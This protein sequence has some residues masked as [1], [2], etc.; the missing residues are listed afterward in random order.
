MANYLPV[1]I[2]IALIPMI[3]LGIAIYSNYQSRK[4]SSSTQPSPPPPQAPSRIRSLT[5][6][7]QAYLSPSRLLSLFTHRKRNPSHPAPEDLEMQSISAAPVPSN[8]ALHRARAAQ[9]PSFITPSA[10]LPTPH[11]TTTHTNRA[12]AL[13]FLAGPPATSEL[14]PPS[15]SAASAGP[16]M[17]W[18]QRADE[19]E[20]KETVVPAFQR[21]VAV[22][23]KHSVFRTPEE[24]QREAGAANGLR[25]GGGEASAWTQVS[26]H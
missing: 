8:E 19:A 7:L 3:F 13:A 25:G 2:I 12:A 6:K 18:L 9:H 21:D 26:L 14:P 11:S 22:P 20:S 10:P 17:H 16:H 5:A 4:T 24:Q 1:Y 15:S 23:G